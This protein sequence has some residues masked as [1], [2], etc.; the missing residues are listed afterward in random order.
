[1]AQFAHN[2]SNKANKYKQLIMSK[3]S[4]NDVAQI[5]DLNPSVMLKAFT[6]NAI[7]IPEEAVDRILE[8]IQVIFRLLTPRS[9]R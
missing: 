1:M 8:D 4:W 3:L 9:E 7:A 2:N 6:P 5:Y